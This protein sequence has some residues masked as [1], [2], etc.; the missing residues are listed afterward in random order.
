MSS[1]LKDIAT[2]TT[3]IAKT[4]VHTHKQDL[5][6][7][8]LLIGKYMT[9]SYLDKAKRVNIDTVAN[10]KSCPLCVIRDMPDPPDPNVCI[11]CVLYSDD[12]EYCNA[13]Y[14]HIKESVKDNYMA[15]AF[16]L[17]PVVEKLLL[18]HID[19]GKR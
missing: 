11:D 4:Y 15:T 8:I 14:T 16:A 1:I 12:T 2:I 13:R 3:D 5:V 7:A 17:K 10:P 18:R 6:D 19:K 9:I